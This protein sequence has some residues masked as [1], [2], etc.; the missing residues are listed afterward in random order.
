MLGI[1]ED[2]WESS[3]DD[4]LS[5]ILTLTDTTAGVTRSTTSANEPGAICEGAG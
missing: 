4:E 5:T 3:S 1:G 2:C